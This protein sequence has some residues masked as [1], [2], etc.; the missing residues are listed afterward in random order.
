MG[1]NLRRQ[2]ECA[3]PQQVI[4]EKGEKTHRSQLQ[5]WVRF[6]DHS[7]VPVRLEAKPPKWRSR[8]KRRSHVDVPTRGCSTIAGSSPPLWDSE[9]RG[10]PTRLRSDAEA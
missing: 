3:I 4:E 7:H 6:T 2:M 8:T 10:D 5:L 9:R 1:A